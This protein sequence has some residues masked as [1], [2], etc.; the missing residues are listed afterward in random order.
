MGLPIA[1]T[2]KIIVKNFDLLAHIFYLQK[3]RTLTWL[4]SNYI[5]SAIGAFCHLLASVSSGCVRL[6]RV[7]CPS[8][9]SVDTFPRAENAKWDTHFTVCCVQVK[10]GRRGILWCLWC[11]HWPALLYDIYKPDRH[12]RTIEKD[13]RRFLQS[14]RRVTKGV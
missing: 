2:A 14:S 3:V 8:H 9:L 6:L 13:F 11:H 7:G 1:L 10:R 4:I 5:L 12:G